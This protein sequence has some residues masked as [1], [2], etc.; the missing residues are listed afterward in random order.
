MDTHRALREFPGPMRSAAV[1]GLIFAT[2]V[3]LLRVTVV[4]GRLTTFGAEGARATTELARVADELVAALRAD[5]SP[6]ALSRHDQFFHVLEEHGGTV[7]TESDLVPLPLNPYLDDSAEIEQ[8]YAER[9]ASPER[10]RV[11]ATAVR[12]LVH[13][14]RPVGDAEIAELSGVD[15][16]RIRSLISGEPR[17]NLNTAEADVVLGIADRV[18]LDDRQRRATVELL[19]AIRDERLRREIRPEEVYAALEHLARRES[20]R[21]PQ[22]LRL[23]ALMGTKTVGMSVQIPLDDGGKSIGTI[24]IYDHTVVGMCVDCRLRIDDA[25]A[26]RKSDELRD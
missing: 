11:F 18:G 1:I 20:I 23:V 3:G 19:R 6:R 13:S 5:S 12:K 17:V 10:A 4:A 15:Y 24:R 26:D 21:P 25:G 16:P 2:T 22:L 9:T 7:S 8:L 14:G